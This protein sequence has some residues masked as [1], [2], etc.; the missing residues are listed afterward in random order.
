LKVATT[1]LFFLLT[2][3]WSQTQSIIG[4]GLTGSDLLNYIVDNYKTGSTLGYGP[5]RDVMYGEIDL[6]DGNLLTGVYSGFTIEL[7][8]SA[9][10]STDA[11][12]K[13]INCEHTWP[14]SMGADSEP[15]RS[16][17]H[18]LFPSKI[19]VNAARGNDPFLDIDDADTDVWYYQNQTSTSI[20]TFNIDLW[21]EKE[22]DGTTAFEVREDHKGNTARAMFY[23]FA[24]YQ[25][26]ADVSFWNSQYTSLL[27]WHY[28]DPVDSVEYDRTYAIA[29]YQEDNPNPFILDSTLAR[30]IWWPDSATND[31]GRVWHV[32]T[33]GSD[34]N[35]DGSLAAPFATIQF[36]VSTAADS[37]TIQ[38]H[39]GVY[40]ETIS[41]LGKALYLTS[42]LYT[43]N[44]TSLIT[45]TIID[46]DS[47][48]PAF[49]MEN[50]EDSTTVIRGLTIQNGS[51]YLADPDGDGF[52]AVYGGGV[53]CENA[54]PKLEN[55]VIKNN[56]VTNGGG[57]GLFIYNGSPIIN[58]VRFLNNRSE[59]VGGAIYGKVNSDLVIKNSFFYQNH[60]ADVGGALY[61]RDS[62]DVLIQ[63]TVI[64][65]NTSDH[66]GAGIGFKRYCYP[67]IN[68]VTFSNNT[69][70]HFG[71][72]IYSNT[73][74]STVEN[75]IFWGN[76]S[77]QIYFATFDDSNSI[78]IAY[79][80]VEGGIESITTNENGSVNWL[81]GNIDSDPLFC[82]SDSMN[83]YL[84]NTSPCVNSGLNGSSMGALDVGCYEL[85][86]GT[87]QIPD[88]FNLIHVYPNPFN[89]RTT[90]ECE[91]FTVTTVSISIIDLQGRNIKS[92][93]RRIESPGVKSVEWDGTNNQNQP[94]S[95]GVYLYQINMY[96]Q[97]FTGKI[98]LL[99]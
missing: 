33:V 95:T 60:T 12:S 6:H 59:D 53:Y 20:P 37:D 17:M 71:S 26:V 23:F 74:Y 11:Y 57:G 50:N 85:S 2:V 94:V 66:A 49:I 18:H 25:D 38:V 69:A 96:N 32:D 21:S 93:F 90:I 70:T 48:G 14:Q 4:E 68:N 62:S 82:D 28:S 92:L 67:I 79:S 24:M 13:G 84:Y 5:A 81:S 58:D 56:S 63:N 10:P 19:E 27:H 3:L 41:M 83:F 51:G 9:D 97:L 15:Q 1:A 35:G 52:S 73:S 76:S 88:R 44:D 22:N 40:F 8:L 61:A 78:S 87:N 36:A 7:D 30:R 39:P 34:E 55:L 54:S 65:F 75:A 29:A 42:N 43:T 89:S 46:A 99:Q 86:N 45:Q 98:L 72:A 47:S 64:A 16:D 80:D 31:G 77:D 91:L